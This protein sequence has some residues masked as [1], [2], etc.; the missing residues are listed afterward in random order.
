MGLPLPTQER[1]E[2]QHKYWGDEADYAQ[3]D[4]AQAMV[5]QDKA[6]HG[7]FRKPLR[8]TTDGEPDH[9]VLDNRCEPIVSTGIDFLYGD[10][11]TWEVLED[12]GETP[13]EAAQ[14][15]LDAVWDANVKMPWLAEYEIN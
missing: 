15:H 11:L 12:D 14:E 10:E 4:P 6:Y 9:N 1:Y 5:R 7:A 8:R 2:T 13:D 3:M